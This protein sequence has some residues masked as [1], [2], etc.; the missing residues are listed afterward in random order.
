MTE[1]IANLISNAIKYSPA[2]SAVALTTRLD[3]HSVFLEVSDEGIGVDRE[4]RRRIFNRFYRGKDSH[5]VSTGGTGLGLALV[6]ATVEAHGGSISI[7]SEPG[8]GS[9]FTIRLPLD[10]T[11][12]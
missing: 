11:L 5:R 6:R 8:K 10:G 12:N 4:D 9:R 2:G 7:T 1:A 3:G